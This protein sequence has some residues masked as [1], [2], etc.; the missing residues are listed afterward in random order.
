MSDRYVYDGDTYYQDG[1]P[2]RLHGVNTPERKQNEPGWRQA[3]AALE[4]GLEADYTPGER[5]KGSYGRDVRPLESPTGGPTLDAEMVADGLGFPLPDRLAKGSTEAVYMRGAQ[6]LLGIEPSGVTASYDWQRLVENTRYERLHA[7]ATASASGALRATLNAPTNLADPAKRGIV[8]RAWDRGVDNMQGTFYGFA[9][10][11]GE[12]SGSDL[13]SDFGEEGLAQNIIEAMQS[14]AEV[15]T[16]DDVDSLTDAG[17]YALEALVEFSPQLATDLLTAIGSGGSSLVLAGAAKALLRKTG[18]SLAVGEAAKLAAA[19]VARSPFVSGAKAG[20]YLSMYAQASGETQMNFLMEGIDNPGLALGVGAAKAGLDYLGLDTVLRGAVKGLTSKATPETITELLA[21]S[22]KATA[23][24]FV[25]ESLTEAT[26]TILDELALKHEKPEYEINIANIREALLKGGIA[27]GGVSGAGRALA[28]TTR[29]MG[30][31]ARIP[32]AGDP[33]QPTAPEPEADIRAQLTNTPAGEGNWYTAENAEQA[34]AVAAELGK[35]VRELADGSVVVA[36]PELLEQLSEA[37]TQVDIAK[38]AGYAQ[39]K[40]EALADPQGVVAVEVRNTDGAVLRNQLVGRSIAEQVAEQQAEK[41]PG[42]KVEITTPVA[43]VET[44]LEAVQRERSGRQPAPPAKGTLT[45]DQTLLDEAQALGIDPER[46]KKRGLGAAVMLRLV[47]GL[48]AK[49]EGGGKRLDA[50]PALARVLDMRPE[51]LDRRYYDARNVIRG[52]DELLAAVRQKAKEKYGSETAFAQAIDDLPRSAAEAIRQELGLREEGGI[53]VGRLRDEVQARRSDPNQAKTVEEMT[54]KPEPEARAE[55]RRVQSNPTHDAVF[56]NPAIRQMLVNAEGKPASADQ[57][58]ENIDQLSTNQRLRLEEILKRMDIDIGGKNREAFLQLL[59]DSTVGEPV[60][61]IGSAFIDD[62][63]SGETGGGRVVV[64]TEEFNPSLLDD[65][66]ARFY[67]LVEKTPLTDRTR[68]GWPTGMSLYL[69]AMSRIIKASEP[70]QTSQ[71]SQAEATRLSHAHALAL[72]LAEFAKRNGLLDQDQM[73]V[74]L[75]EELKLSEDLLRKAAGGAKVEVLPA[76]QGMARASDHRVIRPLMNQLV[77]Q[78]STTPGSPTWESWDFELLPA[79]R[80]DETLTEELETLLVEDHEATI[81]AM[82]DALRTL[83]GGEPVDLLG[84]VAQ[85]EAMRG[86][87]PVTAN[88]PAKATTQGEN[89]AVAVDLPF[90]EQHMSD[91]TFF[92]AVRKASIRFWDVA[93]LPSKEQ[94]SDI[95]FDDALALTLT[96]RFKGKNLL[97]L[98]SPQHPSI[99]SVVDAVSLAAYAQAG[100]PVP[101][102][103]GQAAANLITNIAR[104]MQGSESSNSP[105]GNKPKAL[106]RSIPDDLVIFVDPVTGRGVTFGEGLAHRHA[107]ADARNQLLAA[108]RELDDAVDQAGELAELLDAFA[109]ELVRRTEQVRKTQPVAERA[110]TRWV[111]MMAGELDARGKHYRRPTKEEDEALYRAMNAIGRMKVEGDKQDRTLDQM[112]SEYLSH[113]GA[114]KRLSAEMQ[115]A[116]DYS[117]VRAESPEEDALI[118]GK[119]D[120]QRDLTRKQRERAADVAAR[121]GQRTAVLADAPDSVDTP[122]GAESFLRVMHEREVP[123]YNPYAGDP[124]ASLSID[125]WLGREE[126]AQKEAIASLI[127]A[128]EQGRLAPAMEEKPST[129][130]PTST[131]IVPMFRLASTA[132]GSKPAKGMSKDAV[133]AVVERF[134][135]IYKGHLPLT[136]RVAQ[137]QEEVYGKLPGNLVVKGAYHAIGG[138]GLAGT[139]A[140]LQQG[141]AGRIVL[142][143]ENLKD[144]ADILETLRHEVL[145]HFGLNTFTPEVKRGILTAIEQSRSVPGL[146]PVWQ[147][148]DQRYADMD[149]SYRAEEVFAYIAEQERKGLA[150]LFDRIAALVAQGLRKIGLLSGQVTRAELAVLVRQIGAGIRD[151]HRRQRTFPQTDLDQFRRGLPSDAMLKARAKQFW[152]KGAMPAFS[153]V[154]SMVHSR[155]ARYHEG[156]ARALF[157]PAGAEASALGRSWEQRNRALKSRMMAQLDR[158]LTD[159]RQGLRGKR[160]NLAVQSAFEDAYSG[161]PQTEHGKRIRTLVTQL[162]AEVRNAGLHSIVLPDDFA[163]IAFDRRVVSMRAAEFHKLLTDAGLGQVEAREL[164][165]RIVDGPGV[166]EGAIAP[167]M[168]VGTHAT[169]RTLVEKIGQDK[170]LAGGWLL[171]RHDAALI[172]WID[173]VSKRAAWEG[174]FGAEVEGIHYE[175]GEIVANFDP[176]AKYKA[177]LEEARQTHGEVAVQEIGALVNGAL[178]RHPAGQSMP[179]WWRSTQDFITGWVGMTVL[180]FSGI[181][182][183]PELVMPLVRA[184]GRV[185]IGQMLTDYQA[186]RRFAHDMGIVLSDASEQVMWQ[187]TGDQYRSPFI[188]KAQSLFFKANGNTFLF[189]T[190]RALATGVAIRYLFAAAADRDEG[191]LGRLSI[192]A[193]TIHAW[194]RLGRPAWSPDLPAEQQVIAAKVTDAVNQ[195]VNEATLNPSRF[196]ATHWGNNP[197]LKMIWHLKHFLYTYGDTV[198]LGMWREMRRRWKNLEPWRFNHAVAIATPALIFATLVMPL[199]AAS[200]EARDWVRRLNGQKGQR[201]DDAFDYFSAVFDRAGGLGPVGFLAQLRQQQEWGAS[202]FGSL[203]PVPG[204]V[205]MLLGEGSW[206]TKLRQL[207]PIWSQNKTLFGLLD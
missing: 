147:L 142:V 46:F 194:D 196:Q 145:G 92:S 102:T 202:I 41:F 2:I 91:A 88:V 143:A 23:G 198:L 125:T 115:E 138:R 114:I 71:L 97:A 149:S 137:T 31:G 55:P 192:D 170:L 204:K 140:V 79:S 158:A 117:E 7:L 77:R 122:R 18:G 32:G 135:A 177:M 16:W 188:N 197:Y 161:N 64:P 207:T 44:R 162:V 133:Q 49:V 165:G 60:Y 123:E 26:Q 39:T 95:E 85:D 134:Q 141:V 89:V 178:G 129:E 168:P 201:Y 86:D 193:G 35:P 53:D 151:G 73:L 67:Q 19:G 56:S 82:V 191:A 175:G 48:Q 57:I 38:L 45:L 99:G 126:Q 24:G 10:I 182:S 75:A 54:R 121:G 153:S 15:A 120:P 189:N 180:A 183:I 1:Q 205:D 63:A 83:T 17:V 12:L 22:L 59:R 159:I 206:K 113:L 186:A 157:Q 5:V 156:L 131:P 62:E 76:L 130:R 27:G 174:V 36:E 104:L 106:I 185:G 81:T 107:V 148:I 118:A 87:R 84:L 29:M 112:F 203:G 169:T 184:N 127:K 98:P 160:A 4:M 144:E 3:R 21:S 111:Q 136:F 11:L 65:E 13:L 93:V 78:L 101:T 28:D 110:V 9:H 90:G 128:H 154:F 164:Y 96:Q 51:E 100:E 116:R 105:Y 155:I 42:A 195:F 199:A 94:L 34:K 37:P 43:M 152:S 80:D 109:Q 167:G 173:G 50:V 146:R 25:A 190:T 58:D 74:R 179:G 40:D 30:E 200:L 171:G 33:L 119:L 150:A 163:P 61:G 108:Q 70:E 14:P 8:A 132:L 69:E 72:V 47:K 103:P 66:N 6:K 139:A 20:A 172:H 52:R 176:S 187:A 181:A 68:S 124:L 166:I